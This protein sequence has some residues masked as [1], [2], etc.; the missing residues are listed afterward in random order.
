MYKLY[1]NQPDPKALPRDSSLYAETRQVSRDYSHPFLQ[2]LLPLKL[3][4]RRGK[5]NL[6]II[7][8]SISST[9][10]LNIPM[11]SKS[12]W[13]RNPLL[14]ISGGGKNDEKIFFI[15]LKIGWKMMCW[16]EDEE[17]WVLNYVPFMIG[18]NVEK[19]ELCSKKK[20]NDE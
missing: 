14:S 9:F 18:N 4:L 1:R 3:W 10:F 11:Q 6:I 20:G 2:W 16:K 5:I 13:S 12:F 7:S 17:L 8:C 19:T 15:I